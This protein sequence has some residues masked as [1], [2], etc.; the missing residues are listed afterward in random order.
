MGVSKNRGTPKWMVENGWFGGTPIFG[1]TPINNL[2]FPSFKAP[3]AQS[4]WGLLISHRIQPFKVLS[5]SCSP[6]FSEIKSRNLE[7]VGL[8]LSWWRCQPKNNKQLVVSAILDVYT[9]TKNATIWTWLCWFQKKFSDKNRHLTLKVQRQLSS[10]AFSID[11][12]I[13]LVSIVVW[14]LELAHSCISSIG[15]I[16]CSDIFLPKYMFS[17][18]V[19]HI[20]VY[21][22]INIYIYCIY[23]IKDIYTCS[24]IIVF[25]FLY[26]F[27]FLFNVS[28]TLL[29][30]NPHLLCPSIAGIGGFWSSVTVSTTLLSTCASWSA[31]PNAV[32]KLCNRNTLGKKTLCLSCHVLKKTPAIQIYTPWN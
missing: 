14:E 13:M 29:D 12:R 8:W 16:K 23:I 22:N 18:H 19:F 4:N 17:F 24:Y 26:V 31:L 30:T 28:N 32:N 21:I 11:T 6:S 5:S 10:R 9:T 25:K 15:H 1:N 7:P 27:M 3:I 2:S 20:C